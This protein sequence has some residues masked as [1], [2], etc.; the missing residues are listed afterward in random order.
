VALHKED[1]VRAKRELAQGFLNSK[2]V[3]KHT[4]GVVV[5]E[6]AWSGK[7]DVEFENGTTLRGLT[8]KDVEPGFGW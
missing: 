8:D 2:R 4:D 6:S 1:R 7:V 3:P 5:R